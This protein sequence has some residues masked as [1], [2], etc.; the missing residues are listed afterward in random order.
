MVQGQMGFIVLWSL[1]WVTWVGLSSSPAGL[2]SE[3]HLAVST[4]CRLSE[5]T[6]E[7]AK[8]ATQWAV[9]AG[10][11]SPPPRPKGPKAG[12]PASPGLQSAASGDAQRKLADN[13]LADFPA[14]KGAFILPNVPG[15]ECWAGPDGRAQLAAGCGSCLSPRGPRDV[16]QPWSPLPVSVSLLHH[17]GPCGPA[18]PCKGVSGADRKLP[19]PQ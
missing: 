9:S 18:L 16:P 3:W 19:R 15:T 17:S 5:V 11:P 13:V 2:G 1:G 7:P 6:A 8:E 4:S 10:P 14:V 12:V